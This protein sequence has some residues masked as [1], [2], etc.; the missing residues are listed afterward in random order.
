VAGSHDWFSTISKGS[1]ARTLALDMWD[2]LK[3][4][5]DRKVGN[6]VRKY[7]VRKALPV[8]RKVTAYIRKSQEVPVGRV[9]NGTMGECQRRDL[10]VS[11]QVTGSPAGGLEQR[12]YLMHVIGGRLQ[13]LADTSCYPRVQV[14]R[15]FGE[16]HC[17]GVYARWY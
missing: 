13:H 8:E 1:H 4:P 10:R 6:N 3:H 7:A 15:R 2:L 5:A 9:D 16:C 12:N 11:D 17:I 14:P